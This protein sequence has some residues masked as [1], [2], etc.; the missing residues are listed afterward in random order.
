LCVHGSLFDNSILLI[1]TIWIFN[2]NIILQRNVN[3]SMI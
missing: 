3:A 2:D 1:Q